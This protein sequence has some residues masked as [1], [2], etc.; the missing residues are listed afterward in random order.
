MTSTRFVQVVGIF[1]V[2]LSLTVVASASTIS[3]STAGTFVSSGTTILGQTS[4][5]PATITFTG[6]VVNNGASGSN[7]NFGDMVVACSTC[8]TQA[9]LSGAFFNAFTFDLVITD[10]GAGNTTGEFVGT[11]AGGNIFSDYSSLSIAWTP[12]QLGPGGSHVLSGPGFG[13][14]FFGIYTPTPIVAPNSGTPGA[15][16]DTTVQGSVGSTTVPEPATFL[17]L[18]VSLLGLGPLRRKRA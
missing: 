16:G 3:F 7:V 6:N 17:V 4:G 15:L 5:A 18:G 1:A 11:S 14:D 2:A 10:T 13:T 8:G 9:Q 12:V